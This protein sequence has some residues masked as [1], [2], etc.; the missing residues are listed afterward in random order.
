MIQRNEFNAWGLW[1][2]SENPEAQKVPDLHD[3]LSS[4]DRLL[5]VRS[6]RQDRT[7]LAAADFIR[8]TPT[9]NRQEYVTGVV[10]SCVMFLRVVCSHPYWPI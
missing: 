7:M 5:L 8:D 6:L 9:L 3:K 10:E 4:F 1:Y 2:D